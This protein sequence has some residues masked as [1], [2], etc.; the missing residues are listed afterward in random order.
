MT[1]I[2][3]ARAHVV[4]GSMLDAES[5]VKNDYGITVRFGAVIC[6]GNTLPH[7]VPE[8]VPHFFSMIR[9]LLGPGAPFIIQTLNYAHP[10]IGPNF[11]FPNIVT[12]RFRFE[13]RYEAGKVP[14][15]LAF[16]TTLTEGKMSASD[17]TML[18]PI[19]PDMIAYW[20][21]GAGFRNI[22][23]WSGWD[24]AV[25]NIDRDCYAITVAK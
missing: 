4:K 19:K 21:H 15:T 20:L 8:S 9:R 10:D 18:H 7:L 13:R 3:S 14:G 17:V 16:V 24:R 1:A 6:L 5:I 25:F 12:G 22:E 11:V 2:A 23:V